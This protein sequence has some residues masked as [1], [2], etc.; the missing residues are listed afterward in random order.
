MKSSISNELVLA[1]WEQVADMPPARRSHYLLAGLSSPA[2]GTGELSVGERD[3]RLLLI[4]NRL[5][6]DRIDGV[7][8]C[9]GC[10]ERV[11]LSF[12]IT[13][14]VGEAA[15][16]TPAPLHTD[17]Y[18]VHWRLP[19]SQDLAELAEDT[20]SSQMR[21]KL[22]ERCLLEVRHQQAQIRPL[23]C[24]ERIIQ[25]VCQAMSEADP[26]S[27]TRLGVECPDC[28]HA[29]EV[30]F[31]IGDYLWKEIDVW[32]RRLLGEVHRLAAAYGWFERDILSLTTQRRRMYL[33][34]VEA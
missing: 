22:L 15:A 4:R 26:F 8:E 31:D 21:N 32:T 9:P 27:E 34:M 30:H 25:K 16:L 6:G 7:T 17:G 12:S 20:I 33:E 11:E 23:E 3:R 2:E 1:L 28:R 13:N 10:G 29:W 24:P 18:E 19:T 5:F 14:I